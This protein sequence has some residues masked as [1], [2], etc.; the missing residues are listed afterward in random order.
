MSRGWVL[1][2]ILQH[3]VCEKLQK[4]AAMSLNIRRFRHDSNVVVRARIDEHI[5]GEAVIVLAEMGLTV[6]DAFWMMLS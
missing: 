3:T 6:S 5:R 1:D 2:G 4:W